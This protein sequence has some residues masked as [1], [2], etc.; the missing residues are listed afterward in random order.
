MFVLLDHGFVITT[1]HNK[2][3]DRQVFDKNEVKMK[4]RNSR[5]QI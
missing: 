5:H 4:G 1:T 3:Q 2:H